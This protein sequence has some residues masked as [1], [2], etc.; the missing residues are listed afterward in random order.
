MAWYFHNI[1]WEMRQNLVL[2]PIETNSFVVNRFEKVIKKL[3][4]YGNL[5][6]NVDPYMSRFSVH[7][8]GEHGGTHH[9]ACS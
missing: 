4:N 5:P 3:K 9:T 1:K 6:N 7:T 8:T 2:K